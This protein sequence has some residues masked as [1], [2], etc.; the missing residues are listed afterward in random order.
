ML[1][2]DTDHAPGCLKEKTV[3]VGHRALVTAD[4]LGNL[5]SNDFIWGKIQVLWLV[6]NPLRNLP[7]QPASNVLP[8]FLM[9]CSKVGIDDVRTALRHHN[10]GWQILRVV[11]EIVIH[12]GDEA[13]TG[14]ADARENRVVL[15]EVAT[16]VDR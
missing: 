10:Q 1:H 14:L 8:V 2:R 6:Q 4:F 11:L 12:Y 3:D 13:T 16:K 9:L 7:V 15:A 5:T